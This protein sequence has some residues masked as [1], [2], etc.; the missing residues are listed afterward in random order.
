MVRE[1]LL[2]QKVKIA[3]SQQNGSQAEVTFMQVKNDSQ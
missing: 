2:S 3:R 1:P